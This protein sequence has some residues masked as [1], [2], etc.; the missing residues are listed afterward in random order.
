MRRREV[1]NIVD[2]SP[3]QRWVVVV[4]GAGFFTDAYD[5]FAVNTVLPMISFVY[6]GGWDEK[7]PGIPRNILTALLCATLAGSMI[8]QV[9]FGVLGDIFGRKKMYLY[10]LMIILWGTLGLAASADG[11]NSSMSL[12]GWLF[13]WRFSMGIG[14]TYCPILRPCHEIE[15]G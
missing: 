1:Y 14:M 12:V 11:S 2:E 10:L 5:L 3:V 15:Q 8:G 6:W 7:G 4:A 9:V 13:F